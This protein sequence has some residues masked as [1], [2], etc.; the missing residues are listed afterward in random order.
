MNN[1]WFVLIAFS[2]VVLLFRSPESVLPVLLETSNSTFKF[3]L[4]MC[5]IYAVWLGFLEIM[6]RSG[7]AQKLSKLARPVTKFLFGDVDERTQELLSLN[8]TANLIGVGG[9]A[10]PSGIDA[11]A[12]MQDKKSSKATVNMIMLVVLSSTSLQLLPTT[13]IA[14]RSS[15]GSKAAYDIILPTLISTISS[16]VCGV[17]LVFLI[18]KIFSRRKK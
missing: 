6:Q 11:M 2:L 16:T 13:I 12:A 1:L 4:E 10:T 17:A 14:M 3:C 15:M 18:D 8:I 5:C 7:L 9:A